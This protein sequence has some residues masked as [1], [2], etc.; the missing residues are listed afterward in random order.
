MIE[1]LAQFDGKVYRPFTLDDE[2]KVKEHK[3]NQVV[4][5][6]AYGVGKERSYIQLQRYWVLCT[7]A[8]IVMSDH[9]QQLTR[10]DIDFKLKARAMKKNPAFIK[11]FEV[12]GDKVVIE[13]IS[14]AFR[15]MK[16][17]TA[18]KYF[19]IADKE[20]EKLTGYSIDQ[21]SEVD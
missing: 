8:A 4:R 18:N 7:K 6:Q 3:P 15:N 1:L 21:L 19:D 5:I 14:I 20:L 17:L 2:D 16:H 13:P 11:R 10:E 12:I 9:T